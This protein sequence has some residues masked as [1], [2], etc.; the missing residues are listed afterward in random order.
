[1]TDARDALRPSP[2]CEQQ[3]PVVA[4]AVAD[5]DRQIAELL[6]VDPA[7]SKAGVRGHKAEEVRV[8]A[9]PNGPTSGP[10]R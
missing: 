4:H 6:S 7:S 8:G 5:R 10:R 2:R 1:M 3:L 9:P